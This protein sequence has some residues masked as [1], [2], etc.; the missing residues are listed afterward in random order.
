MALSLSLLCAFGATFWFLSEGR[1]EPPSEA[2][3]P[4]SVASGSESD[5]LVQTEEQQAVQ[6]SAVETGEDA[7]VVF[8]FAKAVAELDGGVLEQDDLNRVFFKGVDGAE[9]W[10]IG[11]EGPLIGAHQVDANGDGNR[12][13]ILVDRKHLVGLDPGGRPIPGF[14]VRPSSSITAQ[15]VVD[16]DGDGKAR[17]LLG[18]ADGRILNHRNLGEA[19]PGWRHTSKSTAIQA[20]AHLRAG[21]KDFICTV[22]EAGVVM[23]LKRNGQRRVRTAAQLHRQEGSRPVAFE[24]ESDIGSSLLISRNADGVV[25]TRRFDD[26]IPLPARAAERQL[27]EAAE[28]RAAER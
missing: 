3:P 18:L 10:E 19:T 4:T 21:R 26:G 25:E 8:S 27:L 22:D 14:S 17:Y 11:M 5:V 7:D 2:M 9:R 23:L 16:Y 13:V 12:E 28:A 24:V 6:E 1:N 15:A 20:I